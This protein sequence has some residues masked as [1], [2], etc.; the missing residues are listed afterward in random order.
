MNNKLRHTKSCMYNKSVILPVVVLNYISEMFYQASPPLLSYHLKTLPC[1]TLNFITS[2]LRRVSLYV[3]LY[4]CPSQL[5]VQWATGRRTTSCPASSILSISCF[6]K[7][8]L[9]IASCIIEKSCDLV[10][11]GS[12]VTP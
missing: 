7:P 6:V 10:P 12:N 5:S 11:F 8:I 3:A 9:L 1:K 4:L 2:E